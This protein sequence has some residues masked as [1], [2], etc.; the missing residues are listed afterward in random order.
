VKLFDAHNHLQDE[1]L[2]GR[3]AEIV[4]DVERSGVVKM[5]VNGSC[6]EDWEQVLAL[7]RRY[8]S[9]VIP[10]FGLHPWYVSERGEGWQSELSRMLDAVPSAIGEIGLDKWI[11]EQS[12]P[13]E[14][15]KPA[16]IEVQEEAFVFQLRLA[17]E[18][19]LP[20]SIHCLKAWGRLLEVL[21][22]EPGPK[23]GFILHSFGGPKE[24]IGPLAELGAYFS[25]PGYFA[26][27]R[28]E[29]QRDAFRHVPLD[30]LLIETDAPD[31]CLPEGRTR[32]PLQDAQGKSVN[33]PANL[34]VV[35]E[36]AAEI[37]GESVEKVA[38]IVEANFK[39]L[40]GT[41][42]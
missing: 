24:M 36:F 1:R 30:R 41:L 35:Y 13:G 23:C 4:A 17:V 5:V 15:R 14:S 21:K 11:L 2:K 9:L 31:Q 42:A 6:E 33:H 20:A 37:L 39:R 16:S 29:R 12:K 40:F 34:V 27:E 10:S 8:P 18:R 3:E 19:N 38:D 22:Q 26:L 25:L 32:F 7:R 28:K